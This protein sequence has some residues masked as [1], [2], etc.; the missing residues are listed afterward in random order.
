VHI[1]ARQAAL[2]FVAPLG[3]SSM[4]IKSDAFGYPASPQQ[5]VFDWWTQETP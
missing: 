3:C 5:S 1:I 4:G 2:S